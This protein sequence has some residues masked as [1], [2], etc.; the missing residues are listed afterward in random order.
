MLAGDDEPSHRATPLENRLALQEDYLS[1]AKADFFPDTDIGSLARTKPWLVPA[2]ASPSFATC[3]ALGILLC[4]QPSSTIRGI[5]CDWLMAKL[6]PRIWPLLEML[7]GSGLDWLAEDLLATV[8]QSGAEIETAA[9][10]A[11]DRP[12]ERPSRQQD[13][14]REPD[15]PGEGDTQLQWAVRYV[16]ARLWQTVKLASESLSIIDEIVLEP[17]PGDALGQAASTLIQ[18]MILLSG[19]DGGALDRNNVELAVG[20]LRRFEEAL[21]SWLNE[22][23]G[24]G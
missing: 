9:Q 8:V 16:T 6:D 22:T 14:A 5:G 4:A 15:L 1:E 2:I 20:P 23:L 21:N 12:A 10:L 19:E 17:S 24:R 11:A 18:T 3:S 13:F 7:S